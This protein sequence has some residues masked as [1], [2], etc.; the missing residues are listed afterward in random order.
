MKIF[1]IKIIY[2]YYMIYM[3]IDKMNLIKELENEIQKKCIE[4]MFEMNK[5]IEEVL[6]LLDGKYDLIY[7]KDDVIKKLNEN[8]KKISVDYEEEII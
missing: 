4:D 7:L 3:N 2:S 5:I 8:M 6:K 1:K